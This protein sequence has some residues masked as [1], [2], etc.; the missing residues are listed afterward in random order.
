MH[1]IIGNT[2]KSVVMIRRSKL[3]KNAVVQ[4]FKLCKEN[5]SVVSEARY[6]GHYITADGKDDKDMT[7]ACRLLYAQGNSLIRKF[8]MCTEKVKIKLF[9]TYCSQVYCGHLWKYNSSDKSYR[10]VNVAYNNVFRSFLR[11]PRDVQGRPC[12]ASGMFVSRKVKSFQEIIRN[13]VYKFQCRISMSVNELV[14]CTLFNDIKNRS[15]M[16]KHWNRILFHD[17]GDEG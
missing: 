12:S 9:V 4:P 14:S 7:K 16:R 2:K 15:I 11:L 8:H 6:L 5:L 17:R 10:K 13:M 1:D 3:L